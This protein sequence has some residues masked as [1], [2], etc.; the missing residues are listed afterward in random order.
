MRPRTFT[1]LA[2]A[3]TT[4]LITSIAFFAPAQAAT[5]PPPSDTI[6]LKPGLNAVGWVAETRSTESLFNE[7]PQLESI[8]SWAA[9][10]QKW[11][12]A[13][14]GLPLNMQQIKEIT[15]G[16]AVYL[17]ISGGESVD[18]ERP[19]E[20]AT[21]T[22]SLSNGHNLT[23]WLGRDNVAL[24]HALRGIG[25]S[26]QSAQVWDGAAK[27][28][29]EPAE[30]ATVNRGDPLL[31]NATG[32]LEWLQPTYVMPP[33]I[34]NAP[35]LFPDERRQDVVREHEG[36]IREVLEFYDEQWA[37]QADPFRLIIYAPITAADLDA[38]Y[39]SG[40]C[41]TAWGYELYITTRAYVICPEVPFQERLAIHTHEYFHVVQKQLESRSF[42]ANGSK[43]LQ[44]LEQFPD[45]M[46]EG[47][48]EF[49]E[50]FAR[51]MM[52]DT[53]NPIAQHRE[54]M[55][56][57]MNRWTPRLA[58]VYDI[59][60]FEYSIGFLAFARLNDLVGQDAIVEL[61]RQP[62][63][64]TSGLGQR[65]VQILDVAA[66]WAEASGIE[67]DDFYEQFDH[68][69][70][71]QIKMRGGE[72]ADWCRDLSPDDTL[73]ALPLNATIQG[74]VVGPDLEPLSLV[75][76]FACAGALTECNPVAESQTDEDGRFS[77]Q[78]TPNKYELA[79]ELGVNCADL[80]RY[81]RI[82]GIPSQIEVGDDGLDGILVEV[83]GDAC[84]T[85][86]TGHVRIESEAIW[87]IS[88]IR[89]GSDALV[90]TDW[91]TGRFWITLPAVA[92]GYNRRLTIDIWQQWPN[93]CDR[94]WGSDS[95]TPRKV[96]QKILHVPQQDLADFEI[97]IEA[98]A[99]SY[100]R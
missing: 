66:V 72:G 27:T 58:E 52:Q 33:L 54:Q 6:T 90:I 57:S 81:R 51:G 17:V 83:R 10:M 84:G 1:L 99:C 16:S 47:S 50:E 29:S 61:F 5:D 46:I 48:A 97:A 98:E 39:L 8:W 11:Q 14:R 75:S 60:P 82:N 92:R 31:I 32:P 12:G 65:W 22:A 41:A 79:I 62:R 23:T 20:V 88:S 71:A 40:G 93:S 18:F 25:R 96:F 74:Q 64:R 4:A 69:Q 19:L 44:H 67:L 89:A 86:I 7:I 30:D 87:K 59:G 28:W 85:V 63:I 26:L 13:A 45:W 34:V 15:P 78:V 70:C 68:W 94:G 80:Y 9:W 43:P 49:V 53:A 2:L 95:V 76:V 37:I 56:R 55:V 3:I 73:S 35:K 38:R 36:Y 100:D 21:G 24:S 42:V 77:L 91:K